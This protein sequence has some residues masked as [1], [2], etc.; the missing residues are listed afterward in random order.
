[1]K[2]DDFEQSQGHASPYMELIDE[3]CDDFEAAWQ[4]GA[5]IRIESCLRLVPEAAYEE[6]LRELLEIEVELRIHNG[7]SVL[8]ENYASRFPEHTGIVKAI[9]Q[10][11]TTRRRL[12]DYELLEQLGRGGMGIVYRARQ[13]YLNQIVALKILPE[14]YMGDSHALSRFRREMQL[15]GG[16]NHPNIVQAYNAGAA[17]G[18]HYLVMEYVA[19][20]TLQRLIVEL[21]NRQYD[22]QNLQNPQHDFDAVTLAHPFSD[23]TPP[24]YAPLEQDGVPPTEVDPSEH[25][26]N[27][28]AN[29]SVSHNANH[30]AGD[31]NLG[32][33]KH[34]R[35]NGMSIGAACEVIRQAALGLHHA[36]QR[37]LVHRDIKPGNLMLEYHGLVKV[38]DLGLGKFQADV[39]QTERSIGPLTQ[40][41]T[42]MGTVD[43]MAPEQWDDPTTV[44]IRADIYSLG[45]T[46]YFLLHGHP[47]FDGKNYG[48]N[49]EK[50]M[51]HIVADP[52]SLR[53][54]CPDVPPELEQVYL[55]LSAKEVINRYQT[56]LEVVEAIERFA[57][58]NELQKYVPTELK[59]RPD[60]EPSTS[61]YHN[62]NITH[63]TIASYPITPS[64]RRRI[65]E[66]VPRP[67]PWY[68]RQEFYA[69]IALFNLLLFIVAVFVISRLW[70]EEPIA[71][72][73]FVVISE[74]ESLRYDSTERDAIAAD[75]IELPGLS[76]STWFSEMPWFTP[77]VRHEVANSLQQTTKPETVLGNNMRGY[78]D[79]DSLNVQQWLWALT[80]KVKG[81][82]TPPQQ[83]LVNDLKALADSNLD[84]V[85]YAE[86]VETALQKYTNGKASLP[87]LA[88]DANTEAMLMHLLADLKSNKGIAEQ[89]RQ[90]YQEA[91]DAY[92]I[93]NFSQRLKLLCMTDMARLT[94][95]TLN[96]YDR[97]HQMYGEVRA[98]QL[99]T[100]LLK[101]EVYTAVGMELSGIGRYDD[102]NFRIAERLLTDPNRINI[103]NNHPLVA[104][105]LERYA[106]S[107]IDQ[108][109]VDEAQKL[110]AK[111][112]S[113]REANSREGKNPFAD[114]Y[115]L[116]NRHGI[117]MT[118]R[119]R[120][121]PVS[122]R[123]QFAQIVDDI[124]KKLAEAEGPSKSDPNTLRPGQLRYLR[125]LRERA[126][127]S[128]YRWADCELFGGA[129]SAENG[130]N[131]VRAETQY[132]EAREMTNSRSTYVLLTVKLSMIRALLGKIP[133]AN[134]NIDELNPV[135][136]SILSTDGRY[137][138]RQA[139]N[140]MQQI[141]RIREAELNI[142]P[143]APT[144]ALLDAHAQEIDRFRKLLQT[145]TVEQ[146]SGANNS[147][148]NHNRHRPDSLEFQLFCIEFLMSAEK[149][150]RQLSHQTPLSTPEDAF[151]LLTTI[152]P[153]KGRREMMPYLR[154]Y[155]DFAIQL[156]NRADL[157]NLALLLSVKLGP[158]PDFVAGND[159]GGAWQLLFQFSP[160]DSFVI[161]RKNGDAPPILCPLNLTRQQIEEAGNLGHEIEPQPELRE[162]LNQVKE[163]REL[164]HIVNIYW[165]DS[166]CW[167][168]EKDAL[169]DQDWPF[170]KL[171]SLRAT[172]TEQPEM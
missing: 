65:S 164:G 120:G 20:V 50:L 113:I 66:L 118:T 31:K 9:L 160:T 148:A 59:N 68:K 130:L 131:L 48:T 44:D 10:R 34:V 58:A 133:E 161:F 152:D 169:T 149:K 98:S 72:Q 106:W 15:I 139:V 104:H 93:D 124:D 8:L 69:F 140:M 55:K 80:E 38:L 26:E 43:Y 35:V 127:N 13:V 137:R 90:K 3:V 5:R 143:N 156:L 172:R 162:I 81:K 54:G 1:M 83:Q 158:P 7:E 101:V 92:A 166:A 53:E 110:F 32:S 168:Y 103:G 147:N 39:M 42:T 96:D 95:R 167:A 51:A 122:A 91:L 36:H 163:A 19:G 87:Y 155:Y 153:L 4:S 70:H 112:L 97:A 171:L 23:G 154:R 6:L 82:L 119:F 170:K 21:V 128:R 111:A 165:S 99:A 129:A 11:H 89:S 105:V 107:L 142:D 57:D 73:E 88:T 150:H 109:Q 132:E 64:R 24:E 78:L 71:P 18:M 63:D 86:Q 17:D 108:W 151:F 74:V 114:I 79:A 77:F 135:I 28:S 12:G 141:V 52:P 144:Q 22:E 84:G 115:I 37:G 46:L 100:G 67:K 126:A 60:G 102:Q 117:A 136:E 62:D 123:Q 45:N 16:L 2:F 29:H 85:A 75:L 138:T 33:G 146:A 25:V 27:H 56:P 116:H 49:R 121:D 134:V 40:A 125:E 30:V 61:S 94:A 145:I 41:G 157:A 14:Q 47:P 159:L 76:G